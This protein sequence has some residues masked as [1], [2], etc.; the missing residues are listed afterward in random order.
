LRQVAAAD[1][2]ASAIARSLGL[3][4]YTDQG[5]RQQLVTY[6]RHRSI[7]LLLDNMEHLL[8]SPDW[9][10]G[11]ALLAEILVSAPRLRILAT[12]RERLHMPEEWLFPLGGL[13]FAPVQSE[14]TGDLRDYAATQLF[15][16]RARQIDSN[17]HPDRVRI[18]DLRAV[19]AVCRRTAGM[20]LALEMAA[21]WVDHVPC[22]EIAAS[23]NDDL[24]ILTKPGAQGPDRHASIQAVF[25]HS[26][27]LLDSDLRRVLARLSVLH[28]P[29]DREA[30]AAVAGGTLFSL[31][32]LLDKS[33]LIATGAGRYQVHEL[34][35]RFAAEKLAADAAL[36]TAT[37]E[38]H[39][40]YYCRLCRT[41]EHDFKGGAQTR[42]AERMQE[43]L[44]NIRAAFAWTVEQAEW[45]RLANASFSLGYFCSHHGHIEEGRAIFKGVTDALNKNHLSDSEA[46]AG[47][48]AS[49][50]LGR[51]SD[52]SS[53]I[54]FLKQAYAYFEAARRLGSGSDFDEA[55][56][57]EALASA[58]NQ[59]DQ[60]AERERHYKTALEA[61]RRADDSWIEAKTLNAYAGLQ[62]W[63]QARYQDAWK[64]VRAALR[65]QRAIDD[66]TG[67]I[68]TLGTLSATE[69]FLRHYAQ[70]IHISK[71]ALAVSQVLG[72]DLR[73]AM[74]HRHVSFSL[75]LAA[76]FD[77]C[78]IHLRH[79]YAVYTHYGQDRL[80]A[81]TLQSLAWRSC[82]GGHFDHAHRYADELDRSLAGRGGH[83]VIRAFLI[84]I[85]SLI[86]F[87]EERFCAA[88]ELAQESVRVLATIGEHNQV[89]SARTILGF[90]Y[91]AL[92]DLESATIEA[93]LF[94]SQG[95]MPGLWGL[96]VVALALVWQYPCEERYAQFYE[97]LALQSAASPMWDSPFYRK[98]IQRLQP[99]GLADF[100]PEQRA[101]A[102]ARGR[103]MDP[104]ATIAALRQQFE[105]CGQ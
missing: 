29:F 71:E 37:N 84:C 52:G 91:L 39:S 5:L 90:S 93:K 75:L 79:A 27:Q 100:P 63:Q 49:Y 6:V 54:P 34:L 35:R 38:V 47:A 57:T 85:R 45:T 105:D 14:A 32:A 42:A 18:K 65:L 67:M 46:I 81:E 13:T 82:M 48:R 7:L 103:L 92:N 26:C 25:E 50:W 56:L 64:N 2:L 16:Q 96:G 60:Y 104:D 88:L 55:L 30:A 61:A 51:L 62:V 77:E 33:L 83:R 95:T 17:Y 31:S 41:L 97:L 78:I 99:T 72:N 53:A 86:A 58:Y 22:V 24:T 94:L 12:S 4:A 11:E 10:A 102:E 19:A 21:A 66:Q 87:H 101:A 20:P 9:D 73:T 1:G 80:A 28:G 3:A 70:A 69:T 74:A 36:A 44:T 68:E 98:I 59:T 8:V 43:S 89:A 40:I 15:L 76:R 23:L